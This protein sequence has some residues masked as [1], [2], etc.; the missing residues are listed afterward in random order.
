M[1]QREKATNFEKALAAR[2]VLARATRD[3]AMLHAALKDLTEHSDALK[4]M[5]LLASDVAILMAERN[6]GNWEATVAEMRSKL[7]GL[8]D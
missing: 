1:S 3:G 6:H 5:A 4:I 2:L 7:A 8:S